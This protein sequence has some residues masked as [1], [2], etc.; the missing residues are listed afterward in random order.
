[1][2]A[3]DFDYHLPED[4]I[5]QRP[6]PRGTAR[7]LVVDRRGEGFAH[8]RVADL[9]GLL[10]PGDL[11]LLN[12]TRVIAARLFARRSTGRRF[13]LLLLGPVD[14]ERWT[15]LLRPTA[16]ARPGEALELPDGGLVVPEEHL[17]EG[18][19]R[20][21]FEPPLDVD[22]L[23]GIG[24]PPL[25][26][27][28]RRPEGATEADRSAYQTVYARVP[29]AVAAPTA[30]LHLTEEILSELAARG[31][32][33][34]SLTLHVGIGTFRPVS[35][36]NV[37][38]HRMHEERYEI[39][40]STARTINTALGEGRR[41]VC[42]GTTSVRALESALA[43]GGG[44]V[45]PGPGRSDLFIRPGHR[46]LGTGALMTNFHLP[47]STLLMLVCA[48]AGRKRTLAAYREAVEHGY[49]FY[50]YGDAMLI[51]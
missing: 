44:T 33:V 15:A 45:R 26:P 46:F 49:R 47:R 11:V 2:R 5:A 23:D 38:E 13:E 9:P 8:R 42:V 6:V 14:H 22:R 50:S 32:E 18:V 41:I 20:L 25:P 34:A 31:V 36:E 21:R 3:S 40:P 43:A 7:L 12:D 30:G 24:E 19:W 10:E 27:Y 51:L 4:R 35:V 39:P 48:L 29:G 37:E 17:G 28:I 1:M 16:R